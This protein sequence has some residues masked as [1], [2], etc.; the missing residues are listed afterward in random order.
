MSAVS[1]VLILGRVEMD[2]KLSEVEEKVRAAEEEVWIRQAARC[3]SGHDQLNANSVEEEEDKIH[4]I[5]SQEQEVVDS[6]QVKELELESLTEALL[7][8][9]KMASE[10]RVCHV[11]SVTHQ[12]EVELKAELKEVVEAWQ[13][14][15]VEM[16]DDLSLER[17]RVAKLAID[18]QEDEAN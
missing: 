11:S 7:K 18:A 16:E 6:I 10:L 15:K 8:S 14:E 4:N 13:R 2:K 17:E 12:Q 3:S 1:K 5:I 9:K